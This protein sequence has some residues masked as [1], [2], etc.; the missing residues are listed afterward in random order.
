MAE[1]AQEGY[2]KSH[3]ASG[4]LTIEFYHPKSNSMPGSLLS[5][6]VQHLHRANTPDIRVIVLKSAG[7]GAFCAGAS[8]DELLAVSNEE[9]GFSFFMGFANVINEIRKSE[10]LVIARVQGK[11]V[12]GGVGIVAAADYAIGCE[13]AEVKLSELAIGI[14]PFVI[15][16]AVERKIGVSAFSQLAI[17]ASMWRSGQWAKTKGLFAE[18]HPSVA[19]MD[20]SVGRLASHL[21]HYSPRAMSEMKRI[22]WQGC[23]SWDVLLAE[24]A[25]IS[26]RLILSEEARTAIEAIRSK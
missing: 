8:F 24:R 17:D 15:G 2:V 18:M 6:L 7:N 19:G 12:G 25:R 1:N 21:A 20:E 3:N 9:E 23:E 10:K 14:G 13:L 11:C 22:F 5:V 4:V 26:G 16:P